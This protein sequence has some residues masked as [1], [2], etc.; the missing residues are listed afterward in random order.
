VKS[1]L[2]RLALFSF[3]GFLAIVLVAPPANGTGHAMAGQ[4]AGQADAGEAVAGQAVAGQGVA[5]QAVATQVSDGYVLPDPEVQELFATDKN[6]ATLDNLGPDGD[7]FLVPRV[8][9]LSDLETMARPTYRLATLELR[10]LTDRLWHLD[11]FGIYGLRIY[12]LGGRD[13]RDV[14]LP[15]GIFV[16]DI[17]WSPDG[18]RIAFLAHLAGGTQVWTADVASGAAQPA[19]DARVMATIATDSQLD[20][21]QPSSMLQWTPA[22]TLITLLV[23]ADR[24]PEPA[25]NPVPSGPMV[26][27][28]REEPL[29]ART[30]QNLL[31]D[32]HD[33]ALF[34]H[35]TRSQIAE[36]APGRPPRLIG[37]PAIYTSISLA[38]SGDHLLAER[39]DRP[40]SYLTGYNGFPHKT[41]I[42]DVQTGSVVETLAESELREGGGRGG[43]GNGN[44]R[45]EIGWRPD[46]RGL[47]WLERAPN[48]EP[49]G[50]E[51]EAQDEGQEEAP[52]PDRI[53]QLSPPFDLDDAV[54]VA[55][56]DDTLS[57]HVLARDG[58]HAFANVN[59]GGRRGLAHF[60]L[61]VAAPAA[62]LI[63]EPYRD[64]DPTAL[65]GELWT[66]RTAGGLEYALLSS[67]ATAAYL[68]GDGYKEDFRPQPFVDRVSLLDASRERVFEGGRDTFDQPLTPLDADLAQMIVSRESKAGFPDSFLWRRTD[69]TGA[70]TGY[71]ENLTENVDPFPEVT[72]ARRIDF[73]FTRLDGLVVQAR[74]SLPVG[75]QDGERVPAVFWTYPREYE[76]AEDYQRS[77]LRARNHNAFTHMSWLRW[78]DIWL[79]QG[80]ALVYPDIPII[81]DPYN[82]HFINDMRDSM[83]AAIRAVDNAGWVDIDR[84]GHG[85]H[86][87]GAFT[88]ANVLAH[89]PFFKAGIA[90][91]GAYNRSLTP[92]GFQSEGRTI[93]EAPHIYEEIAPFYS[94]DQ[95]DAP[96]L[97]YHG[98]D[99][100][101]SGT[102]PIQSERMIQALTGLGKTA[103]LYMYPFESHTPRAIENKL[104]M[105]ARFIDWFDTNVK[106]E[107]G[108]S[109]TAGGQGR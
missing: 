71:V 103:V 15:D 83:Y 65:P 18:S 98:A 32:A 92:G 1:T 47:T 34:E 67:D 58:N 49:A 54:V 87:Y 40:F 75:Y 56:S 42:I 16:S 79:T 109:T 62:H 60:D 29:P 80:Y 81:G 66:R 90:G 30:T 13:F 52:R 70:G 96:L 27:R 61:T 8:T 100:N 35:Y 25:R 12:S 53:M 84:I 43:S 57:G 26:R 14:Q 59:R 107:G 10:P 5:G 31:R 68:E 94:A 97:M 4:A 89:A 72:A 21:N 19:S 11:T 76:S 2:Q 6:Y 39:I 37:E 33:A 46:G 45:R 44:A 69:A 63:V 108:E 20:A 17:T 91:D 41:Q 101:N 73:E 102:W 93:W 85:G 7:H 64:E 74:I 95:I 82:D 22:G 55:E 105:W 51:G 106:G 28:T 48:G 50:G 38:P 104:D 78:S 3:L 88:T 36:L 24:G 99:D 9:E 77:A 86:S 23:P